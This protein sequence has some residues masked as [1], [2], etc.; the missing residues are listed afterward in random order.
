MVGN[1]TVVL[2][3]QCWRSGVLAKWD[4]L[5]T[6]LIARSNIFACSDD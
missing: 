6:I 5:Q 2:D 3:L 1:G 4:I